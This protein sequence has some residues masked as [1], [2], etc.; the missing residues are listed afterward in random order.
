MY[1]GSNLKFADVEKMVM[2]SNN[3][4]AKIEFIDTI[5]AKYPTADD[6]TKKTII[7]SLFKLCRED[8]DVVR[9]HAVQVFMDDI[10]IPKEYIS[11]LIIKPETTFTAFKFNT[12]PY[13]G[14]FDTLLTDRLPLVRVSA[15]Q[16]LSNSEFDQDQELSSVIMKTAAQMLNDNSNL[17]RAAAVHSLRK[18]TSRNNTKFTIEKAQIRMVIAM[19]DDPIEE[20]RHES[21]LLIKYLL[22]EDI[23][24][25][26]LMI[27]GIALAA[28]HYRHD[29][30]LYIQSTRS[31]GANNWFFFHLAVLKILKIIPDEL[32]L[33]SMTT[34]IPLAALFAARKVQCFPL[35]ESIA[36]HEET[37]EAIIEG[38]SDVSVVE[39]N[40]PVNLDELSDYI[41]DNSGNA[42]YFYQECTGLADAVDYVTG[43]GKDN[44]F[45]I[46]KT[47]DGQTIVNKIS[48]SLILPE[49]NTPSTALVYDRLAFF[50]PIQAK[51]NHPIENKL[52]VKSSAAFD[53]LELEGN[54]TLFK[55]SYK[56]QVVNSKIPYKIT[57]QFMIQSEEGITN[58]GK[59]FDVWIVGRSYI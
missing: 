50:L 7:F 49:E 46:V 28:S 51:L 41:K 5:K 10:S 53:P 44:Y 19:L 39:E 36:Q 6:A 43:S 13:F 3:I 29:R 42:N 12:Y 15:T 8:I 20:N 1:T 38:C 56:M 22:V 21:L 32:D 31:F 47:D 17:V 33:Y 18:I 37:I 14:I 9:L 23:Q 26:E 45:Q 16:A 27:S 40:R 58:I 4:N 35:P 59:P 11:N 24:Q 30:P 34:V 25:V 55:G 52:L 54:G 2:N 48:V 57:L